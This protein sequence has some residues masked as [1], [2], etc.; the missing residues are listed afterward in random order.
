MKKLS[1]VI[2]VYLIGV[3]A[4]ADQER[5]TYRLQDFH[6]TYRLDRSAQQKGYCFNGLQI[7]AGKEY[8]DPRRNGYGETLTLVVVNSESQGHSD[9]Q[10]ADFIPGSYEK[11]TPIEKGIR[12]REK[13]RTIFDG[14]TIQQNFEY[15]VQERQL[16]EWSTYSYAKWL[17]GLRLEDDGKALIYFSQGSA[18][19]NSG[20]VVLSPSNCRYVRE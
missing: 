10:I 19:P 7:R 13:S 16:F 3:T 5:K 15:V 9:A 1:A 18:S 14:A 17:A 2:F 4:F 8:W 12:S 6:G 11:I 20:A